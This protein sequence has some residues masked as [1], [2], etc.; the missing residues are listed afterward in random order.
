M[1]MYDTA[2]SIASDLWDFLSERFASVRRTEFFRARGGLPIMLGS[3]GLREIPFTSMAFTRN[4]GSPPN[5]D[6]NDV[7]GHCVCTWLPSGEILMEKFC[8]Y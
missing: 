7:R 8:W 2:D 5:L 6:K 1:E 3:E 4:C